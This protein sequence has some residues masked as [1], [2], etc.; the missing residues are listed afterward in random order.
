MKTLKDF[1]TEHQGKVA[2]KWA[3]YIP[4]YDSLLAP[5][6]H[7]PIALLEIG[8][9]NGGSLEI[10]DRYFPGASAI[11][12]CDIDPACEMLRFKS[13]TIHIVTGDASSQNCARQIGLV[14]SDLDI[15]VDD[16]SHN[17]QDVIG[18]F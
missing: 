15:I 3:S 13:D 17:A 18:S 12:G 14:A 8:V 7:E 6:R 4:E 2:D 10:W 9:E 1:F 16:G 5:L 11:I